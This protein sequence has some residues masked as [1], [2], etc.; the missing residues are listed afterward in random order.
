MEQPQFWLE[1]P[2]LTR[3]RILF[4]RNAG[5]DGLDALQILDGLYD[6]AVR[7]H[8]VGLKME[9][10]AVRALVLDGLGRAAEA[11][12]ALLEAV[13]LARPGG[14][15]RFFIELGQPM[16]GLL[17]N[18][19]Q[20]ASYAQAL[21]GVLAAFPENGKPIA[22]VD[23]WALTGENAVNTPWTLSEPLTPRELQILAL[24]QKPL[25]YK[26]IARDLSISYPTIKRHT[27]NIYGKLRVNSRWDAVARGVALGIISSG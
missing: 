13:D 8:N 25:S 15:I 5:T 7:N 21:G 12:I 1:H 11:R 6:L 20:D 27:I 23:A 18:L 4:A 19:A 9:T 22:S 17:A 26:Q 24:M 14:F 16:R 10:Q 3:A 2:D